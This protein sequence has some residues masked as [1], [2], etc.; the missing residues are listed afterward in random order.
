[1]RANLAIAI[2]RMVAKPNA[3]DTDDKAELFAVQSTFCEQKLESDQ[4][5][6]STRPTSLSRAST[7]SEHYTLYSVSDR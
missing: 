7:I 5:N 2:T 6:N 1:M 4:S 3:T